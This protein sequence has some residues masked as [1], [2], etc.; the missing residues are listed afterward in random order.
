MLYLMKLDQPALI[1]LLEDRYKILVELL[2]RYFDIL[3]DIPHSFFFISI[4]LLSLPKSYLLN[5][6]INLFSEHSSLSELPYILT[7]LIDTTPQP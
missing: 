2:Y 3:L 4:L 6:F 7:T 1:H 5:Y